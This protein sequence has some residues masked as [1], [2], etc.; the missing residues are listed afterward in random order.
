MRASVRAWVLPHLVAHVADQ[1][2]DA[3]PLRQ[4]KGL[5]EVDFGD[6]DAC[7]ADSVAA[8]AWRRAE[9]ISGDENLGLH[10]AQ[11]LPAGALD[12]VEYAF[13][14]SHSLGNAMEQLARYGRVISDRLAARVELDEQALAVSF[15]DPQETAGRQRAEFAVALLVRFAREASGASLSP[16][17]VRFA[18]RPP[19][20]LFEHRAFF[21][22][23]LRFEQPF[24]QVLF[25]RAD[26][27]RPLGSSD[28]ALLGVVSRRLDRMLALCAPQDD[29]T[30]AR[31]RRVLLESLARGEPSAAAVG[32]E[33]GLSE[34]T[35]H[36]RLRA[37]G[38][39]FRGI[40][41]AV[42]GELATALLREPGIGIAEIA[43]FLGY[44]EPAAFHRSFRRWTGQTPLAFR[45]SVR[46]A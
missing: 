31:V 7:V 18:H 3:T 46:A 40:L 34:R 8:E 10:L 19:E 12:L 2:H 15:G 13:R 30:A 9:R 39:W 25:A 22:A 20:N 24:N 17:E 36:R 32:R 37:E 14:S 16:L 28:P 38:T 27:G 29:S 42:R 6:P 5:R 44:S 11:A 23:P 35:L 33:L 1:R 26:A 43:F 4:L 21:R 45:R 41:D